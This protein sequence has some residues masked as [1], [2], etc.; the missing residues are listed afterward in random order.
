MLNFSLQAKKGDGQALKAL[1]NELFRKQDYEPA[2]EAYTDALMACPLCFTKERSIMYSNRAACKYKLVK[3]FWAIHCL[4]DTCT[5]NG[6]WIWLVWLPSVAQVIQ[7]WVLRAFWSLNFSHFA[8]QRREC[9]FFG[10]RFD[11]I[12]N[13]SLPFGEFASKVVDCNM[14]R[15]YLG[16]LS[17]PRKCQWHV[18][19]IV[20]L[21]G[22]VR[23]W[24]HRLLKGSGAQ[25]GIPQGSA[26]ESRAL[27]KDWQIGR[28]SG[29]LPKSVR[30]GSLYTP[31]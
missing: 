22:K 31:G 11:T 27:R 5:F 7:T 28:R 18:C 13:E 17:Y 29:R 14:Y 1:G 8:F 9:E 24:N 26:A 12:L 3:Y 20:S 6:I 10:W 16:D 15:V 2:I 19:V 25:S 4:F 21:I 23:V 30:N